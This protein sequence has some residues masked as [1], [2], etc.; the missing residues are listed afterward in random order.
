M[1]KTLDL[2]MADWQ[3]AQSSKDAY[4]DWRSLADE[5]RQYVLNEETISEVSK[6]VAAKL[7]STLMSSEFNIRTYGL[8]NYPPQIQ[9]LLLNFTALINENPTFPLVPFYGMS[10]LNLAEISVDFASLYGE[11]FGAPSL[12]FVAEV[13]QSRPEEH[14]LL[15]KNYTYAT[16]WQYIMYAHFF[17][18][19][20]YNNFEN[21]I[22]IGSGLGRTAELI[23]KL[24]THINYYA[25]ELPGSGYLC[26]EILRDRFFNQF[27][28]YQLVRDLDE[29]TLY[30]GQVTV[31]TP[32]HLKNIKPKGKTLLISRWAIS[33]ASVDDIQEILSTLSPLSDMIHLCDPPPYTNHKSSGPDDISVYSNAI[34]NNFTLI[35]KTQ[36]R[37]PTHRSR[38][39]NCVWKKIG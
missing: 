27:V 19:E 11:N 28:P 36:A 5:V 15:I 38:A 25:L 30:N 21:V 31:L 24:H 9:E 12:S 33:M 34:G 23:K 22:E 10:L 32:K 8:Q 29:I 6:K 7:S 4:G 18:H 17:K 13:L 14:P 20:N 1:V 26:H 3:D 35:E 16:L 39:L 2:M 37:F